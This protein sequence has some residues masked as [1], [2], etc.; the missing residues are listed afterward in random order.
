MLVQVF[1]LLSKLFRMRISFEKVH[2]Q[3]TRINFNLKIGRVGVWRPAR[4]RF[5]SRYVVP[6]RRSGRKTQSYWA[7]MSYH[8]RGKLI[9]INRRLNGQRYANILERFLWPELERLFPEGPIYIIEDN[10]R[11]HRCAVVNAWY[12]QHGRLVRLP[13]PARSPGESEIVFIEFFF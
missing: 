3:F 12:A 9:K 13:H 10:S 11:I 5:N 8:G 7:F 1:S 6:S 2:L 4:S